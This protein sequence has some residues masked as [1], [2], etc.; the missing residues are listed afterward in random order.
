VKEFTK[1]EKQ[2]IVGHS[3]FEN[4]TWDWQGYVPD[5]VDD[6][7]HSQDE[8]LWGD[9]FALDSHGMVTFRLHKQ[10][11]S[12]LSDIKSIIDDIQQT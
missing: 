2:E 6:S 8:F 9:T 3:M 1:V 12:L 11:D 7:I 10:L 4:K 5:P